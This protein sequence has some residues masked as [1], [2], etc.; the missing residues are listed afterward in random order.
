MQSPQYYKYNKISKTDELD[1]SWKLD[2]LK[3]RTITV[4]EE[5]NLTVLYMVWWCLQNGSRKKDS[6]VL[7]PPPHPISVYQRD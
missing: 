6:F 7:I 1:L 3:E 2:F 5:I 4:L